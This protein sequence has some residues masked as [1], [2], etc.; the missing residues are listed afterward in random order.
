[1]TEDTR[2]FSPNAPLGRLWYFLNLVF[3]GFISVGVNFAV[4]DYIIPQSKESFHFAVNFITHII[5]FV[6]FVTMFMLIERRI[7]SI[8]R[9]K[10]SVIH[11]VLSYISGIFFFIFVIQFILMSIANLGGFAWSMPFYISCMISVVLFALF[12][13]IIGI[14]PSGQQIKN[15]F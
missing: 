4:N 15:E 13:F 7:K 12:I 14:I 10:D 9:S 8:N 11:K 2:L 3:V 6:L 1:M 5:Y